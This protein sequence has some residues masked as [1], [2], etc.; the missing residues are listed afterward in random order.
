MPRRKSSIK[1]KRADK[2]RHVRNLKV[3]KELKNIIKKFQTLLSTD[4]AAE[5][6]SLLAQVFSKLD[7]AAKKGV[8]HKN[9]AYRRK[10]RL[11]LKVLKT[12]KT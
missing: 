7:K 2:K 9:E 11:S 10:S 1:R 5:A 8:I 12:P 4:K 3:K 6:K